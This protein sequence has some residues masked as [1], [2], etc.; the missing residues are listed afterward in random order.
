[1]SKMNA[2]KHGMRGT[3]WKTLNALLQCQK[4]VIEDIS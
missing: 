3:M 2:E 4:E 1:M